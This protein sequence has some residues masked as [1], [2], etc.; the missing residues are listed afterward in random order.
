MLEQLV[1]VK[2]FHLWFD[3]HRMFWTRI[4]GDLHGIPTFS[5]HQHRRYSVTASG[6][7]EK[8]LGSF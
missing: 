7:T 1:E 2:V 3:L 6:L 5:Y 4:K 8:R